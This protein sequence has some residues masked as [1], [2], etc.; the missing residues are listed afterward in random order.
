[1]KNGRT[2]MAPKAEHALDLETNGIVV[3]TLA[4]GEEGDTD[5]LCWTL[6]EAR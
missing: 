6:L 3:V 4:S 2:H 1:M 5:S